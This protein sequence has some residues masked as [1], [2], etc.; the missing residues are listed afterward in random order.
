MK[1]MMTT[2]LGEVTIDNEA[3]A[4]YAGGA[5]VGCMGVVGMAAAGMRD[6]F[7]RL[8]N[9]ESLT[10]G[11][12]VKRK[13]S[14]VSLDLHVIIAYGSNIP[15]IGNNLIQSVKYAVE[16]H[17]GLRVDQIRVFVDGVRVID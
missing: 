2:S 16:E 7:G 4:E 14:H 5:A 6:G 15:A 13:G 1:E 17:T 11:I 12:Y 10:R 9:R 3:L 8:L